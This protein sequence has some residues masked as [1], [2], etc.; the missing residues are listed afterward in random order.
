MA[1]KDN[2]KKMLMG[3]AVAFIM[4]M[5]TFAIVLNYATEPPST[6]QY[7]D[8]KFK[9][10]RQ[11][12][13]TEI[14]GEE[15]SFFALPSDVDM[16]PISETA[17]S[18]LT[19]DKYIVAYDPQSEY[20]EQM[21][22]AQ[23]ML[24]QNLKGIERAL[25]NSTGTAVPQKNCEDGTSQKPVIIFQ[26][27]NETRIESDGACIQAQYVDDYDLFREEELLRYKILGVIE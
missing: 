18:L 5:S 19:A 17:K 20:A 27:A 10:T 16:I 6:I 11:G 9:Q 23:F 14:D 4:I 3:G 24:E 13:V 12:Y 22:E 7:L 8:Y 26:Q 15:Q 2:Q 21:A 1:L 25:T